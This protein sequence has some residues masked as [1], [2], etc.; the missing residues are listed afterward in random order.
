MQGKSTV[1]YGSKYVIAL[2][3]RLSQEDRD[4][5][6]RADKAESN[7]VTGQKNLIRDY[8]SRHPELEECG[9]AVDDGF[10]GSSFERPAF[11]K[12]MDDVRARKIDCIV[13]KDLS[14]FGRNYLDAGEYIEKIFPFLGVRLIAVNDN[15][16]S[17]DTAASSELVVPFK[18]LI[19]NIDYLGK[20]F[21]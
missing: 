16:D 17:L 1:T 9:M 14:R 2:Y 8:F 11:Q 15:F 18:N 7:S 5:S 4:V 3:I 12:M 6:L 20:V 10:S 21:C 13:V 19:K